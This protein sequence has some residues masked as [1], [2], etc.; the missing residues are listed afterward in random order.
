MKLISLSGKAGAGKD[1]I[2]DCL[3]K[4]EGFYKVA[5]ADSL[6][7]LAV[8]VFGYG[9]KY[10]N[11]RKL[12]EADFP[13][14]ITIDYDHIDKIMAFVCYDWGYALDSHQV[15]GL[16]RFVGT[17]LKTPRQLLQVVG[18]DMLRSHVRDDIFIINTFTK[19]ASL[20]YTKIVISDA[21]LQNEREAI[22]KAGGKLLLVK[23]SSLMKRDSHVSE[24]SLG[25]DDE[26][27]VIINNEGTLQQLQSEVLLWHS[28]SFKYR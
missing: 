13:G 7:E 1:S 28:L 23:R 5:L 19:V 4:Y 21:R 9:P 25:K 26:Y 14:Y 3:V 24:N 8:K 2:A 16:E 15:E 18:T 27:D 10:Y 12:K 22:K 17:Q 11:D 20:P 6:K